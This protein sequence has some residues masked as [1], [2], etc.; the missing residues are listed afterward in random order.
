MIRMKT[1][2]ALTCPLCGFTETLEMPINQCLLVHRCNNCQARVQPK[3]G[4]C[5]VFCSY[6][7][8]PCPS[9]Q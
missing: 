5:C 1:D 7:D 4:D 2:S 8:T 6:G 3:T 9:K